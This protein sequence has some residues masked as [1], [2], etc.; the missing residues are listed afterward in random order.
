M[1]AAETKYMERRDGEIRAVF[2]SDTP[3]INV[4][5]GSKR[6]K[7]KMAMKGPTKETSRALQ[8][9]TTIDDALDASR[10]HE[11]FQPAY[12]VRLRVGAYLRRAHAS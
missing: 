2:G 11:W 6:P 5:D 1:A 12:L 7:A 10:H 9:G 8:C 3:I 4:V